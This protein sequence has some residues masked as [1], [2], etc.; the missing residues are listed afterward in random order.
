MLHQTPSLGRVVLVSVDPAINNGSDV[1][2]G[3]IVRVWNDRQINVKV[4]LDEHSDK[5]MPSV[6]LF[7]TKPTEED[8]LGIPKTLSGHDYYAYWPPKV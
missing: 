4:H 7:D 5:W 2:P 6:M 3:T 1:A 8:L